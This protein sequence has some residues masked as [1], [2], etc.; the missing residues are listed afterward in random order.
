V[1]PKNIEFPT[2]TKL[3][4]KA[5]VKLVALADE[6]KMGLRQNYNLISK[7][8][9][10]KIGGYLH[11]QQHK[12]AKKAQ[13]SFKTLVGRVMRDCERRLEGREEL[14]A[15]FEQILQQTKHLLERKKDDKRKLYSLHE[16]DV[17]CI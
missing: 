7:K 3:L 8:L 6:N 11:A 15:K 9:L 2:D 16:L 10:R 4:E 14:Q 13:R 12:R 1:M 5:R 17:D